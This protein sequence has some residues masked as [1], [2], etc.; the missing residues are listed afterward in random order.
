MAKTKSKQLADILTFTT[1]SID[2]VSGSLI[3]DAANLYN[4]GSSALP[5]K[6][7]SFQHLASNSGSFQNILT[8]QNA[9]VDGELVVTQY[10]KHK[11]D[12][13]TLINFTDNRVRLDAGGINFLSLEKDAST[14]YP[15][16]VNKGGNRINFRVVDRNS[17]LLLKTDS[18]KFNVN[19]Y[20][21]GNE[22]LQTLNT[23]VGI[24]GSMVLKEQTTTPTAQ[25]G[26]LMYSGSNFYLG[27]D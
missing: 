19:L 8:T 15:L 25:E 13:N 24:T 12:T 4:I 10:I 1:A 22:K 5:Y 20:Y 2:V 27:F 23:G 21:A 11:G 14:P 16:T 17:D 18:E 26:G 9:V 3:P 7:G 6:S